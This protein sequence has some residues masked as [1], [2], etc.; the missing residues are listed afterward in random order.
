[1]ALQGHLASVKIQ[2]SA[3]T[4]TDEP[5]TAAGD[6]VYQI[7]NTAHRILDLNT[8]IVVE[9]GGTATTESYTID[10]L[11]GSVTF[12]DAVSRTITITGA[13]VALSTVATA[14]HFSFAGTS[15]ILE[16]TPFNKTFKEFQAGKVTGTASLKRYHVSDDLFFDLLFN[17]TYAI[18]E[19][20]V[21]ATQK[22]SFYA[23]CTTMNIES[24][25]EALIQESLDF[26]ITNQMGAS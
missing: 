13:Y 8:A 22:I 17:G 19:Y 10:Y 7:T 24:P 11:N 12:S 25:D 15:V 2:S 18:I 5:T 16:N 20:Y 1:M 21:S 14:N 4:I 26:Q 3:V 9:D 23:L 6:L